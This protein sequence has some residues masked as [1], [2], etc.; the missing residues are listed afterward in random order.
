[1]GIVDDGDD[2]VD[3]YDG[4]EVERAEPCPCFEDVGPKIFGPVWGLGGSCG[5]A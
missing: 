3:A 1:V 2:V 4:G 5:H